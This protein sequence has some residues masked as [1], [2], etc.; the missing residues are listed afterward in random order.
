MET[1]PYTLDDLNIFSTQTNKISLFNFCDHTRTNGGSKALRKRMEQPFS[2]VEK[3]L[4]VQLSITYMNEH[5]LGFENLPKNIVMKNVD[6]YIGGALPMVN[7]TNPI[8]FIIEAFSLWFNYEK[9]YFS[10]V[11]GVKFT[12][13]LLKLLRQ[14]IKN[15]PKL[16][17]SGEILSLLDEIK[18]ILA[19]DELT[20]IKSP[21]NGSYSVLQTI[22]LD[23][24]FRLK[25]MHSIRKLI[26][27]TYEID[28]L[29]AMA[30]CT[31]NNGFILPDIKPG[32]PHIQA[33]ELVQPLVENAIGN[34]MI[35]HPKKPLLFLTGPNMAG[36]STYLR[37][38]GTALY[39]AHLGM[40]VPQ[41]KRV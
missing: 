23:Q 22:R 24:T 31:K 19:R 20:K 37:A 34:N 29:M 7:S 17:S 25:E 4:S 32:A 10:I 18:I 30:I 28:A 35:L 12:C 39:L 3:I 41:G 40:G 8:E 26:L 15:M 13:T 9:F 2:T 11:R 21:K 5:H 27:L 38:V 6:T 14:L 33:K 36:K 16:S 1:D